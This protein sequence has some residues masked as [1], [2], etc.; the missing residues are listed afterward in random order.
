MS[1]K[2][3]FTDLASYIAAFVAKH[4]T[5]VIGA[6]VA[7]SLVGGAAAYAWYA[8]EPARHYNYW[9]VP[10]KQ[11][12]PQPLQEA[13]RITFEIDRHEATWTAEMD[14]L[15]KL[16]EGQKPGEFHL[17]NEIA[18]ADAFRAY[19]THLLRAGESA[20]E[21][22][23]RMQGTA[24][25]LNQLLKQAPAIYRQSASCARRFVDDTSWEDI[26]Q[27]Y[28]ALADIYEA[29]AKA[30]ENHQNDVAANLNSDL[31]DYIKHQ[32]VF[33]ERLLTMLNQGLV[34]KDLRE[35][36]RFKD[37]LQEI[38]IKHEFL[39]ETLRT[40]RARVQGEPTAPKPEPEPRKCEAGPAAPPP[41][42][43][44]VAWSSPAPAALPATTPSAYWEQVR[45][46]EAAWEDE[47]SGLLKIVEEEQ[48]AALRDPMK[49]A[50]AC[51]EHEI[52]R[53]NEPSP[54]MEQLLRRGNA[55]EAAVVRVERTAHRLDDLLKQSLAPHRSPSDS[56]SLTER[57]MLWAVATMR[58]DGGQKADAA[59]ILQCVIQNEIKLIAGLP[60]ELRDINSCL[61]KHYHHPGFPDPDPARSCPSNFSATI[62]RAV[63]LHE[64]VRVK[65]SNSR[66]RVLSESGAHPEPE[67]LQPEAPKANRV[68]IQPTT[69]QAS[70]EPQPLPRP[71]L[72]VVGTR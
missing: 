47:M 51:V 37:T 22:F 2:T 29:K 62:Q 45:E 65:L 7:A 1:I 67:P 21:T 46:Q 33:L 66:V 5:L 57:D 26:K 19:V 64:L 61:C 50:S 27:N 70:F 32:Q 52:S 30:A 12:I 10:T 60:Q 42:V 71:N 55:I 23:V 9:R 38:I 15:T 31:L 58:R 41:K 69:R 39:R 49:A 13:G 3:S 20:V 40:W 48:P 53:R 17:S 36:A 24:R 28:Q 25:E 44:H 14:E 8:A 68:P 63:E 54:Y 72:L 35:F 11:P 56:R 59:Y 6:A 16:I 43:K 18:T 34:S 4:R